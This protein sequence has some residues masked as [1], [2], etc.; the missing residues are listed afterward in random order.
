MSSRPERRG[1]R[2]LAVGA[3]AAFAASRPARADDAK[4]TTLVRAPS[5]AAGPVSASVDGDEARHLAGSGGDPSVAAQ[6]L[7]GVARPAPG[8]TGLVMWGATPAETRVLFDGV[9]IP[10]L[11]H[12]G[13][14]RATVGAELVGRVEVVPGAFAA[15]YGDALGGLV[16]VE[17]RPLAGDGDGTNLSLDADLLDVAASLRASP[18]HH[19]HVAAAVRASVLDQTYGRFAPAAATAL[20]PVPRYADAQLEATWEISSGAS[21]RALLL[22]SFDR[23][24]R[25]LGDAAPG[26]ADRS[27]KQQRDWWRAAVTYEERGDDDGLTATAFVGGDHAT[28]DQRFGATPATQSL[29]ATKLGLRASYRARLTEGLRLRMG[30]D[31][32]LDRAA[33]HRGGSLTVPAREG[34]LTYFGQPPGDDVNADSWSGSVADV[35]TFVTASFTR[36]KWMI[37]PGLRA[38]AFPIDASRALP[39]VGATPPFGVARLAWA[40]DPRLSV[41]YAASPALI[42]TAAAGAYHQAVEPAD[43]SAVFGNPGLDPGRAV[44]ATLSLWKRLATHLTG[45][46]TGFYRRLDGLAV[47]SSQVPPT[48]AGALVG[49]GRG[50]SFGVDVV[51]RRAL[52]PGTSGWLT[53]TASRAE[54]WT[55][56]GP[57][58][59]FDF[60][61]THVVT[62]I[63][64]HQRGP[65]SVSGRVRYATGMPRTPL[66]SSFFDVRDGLR[67][68]LF[69][70]QNSVRLPAFVQVD[71]RLDRTLVAGPVG[72]TLYLDVQ[73]I[74]GRR[75]AEEIVYT[76]DL[77]TSGY[78]TGP[79]VLVLLG[80]RLES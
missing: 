4:N 19:L 45:E 64:S 73:N 16:R 77:S 36:G 11:Y 80:V 70:A 8:A 59:L 12:F 33:L 30:V 65:W 20:F 55:A 67:Q 43:L 26:L 14:F 5:A 49:D 75:N 53:Y 27:E 46:V 37:A 29:D 47:R 24:R 40:L 58:R 56:D 25:D 15:D 78:F 76:R 62:A 10:A 44:H 41:V 57:V 51:L 39:P 50:R 34:D 1:W 31:G 2:A 28:L 48:L 9:D 63:A 74:F 35:G 69:G 3:V 22:T 42:I 66:T 68:P 54:R 71:A 32:L 7:P 60:D 72:V 23:Q 21:L 17:S 18:A 61:Q 52:G 38:D 13:G 6:N 79:P